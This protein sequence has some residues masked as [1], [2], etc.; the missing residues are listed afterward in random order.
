MTL[1]TNKMFAYG[2]REGNKSWQ[3]VEA[4]FIGGEGVGKTLLIRSLWKLDISE[5][6]P[7]YKKKSDHQRKP[8]IQK[9]LSY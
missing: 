6:A 7:K 2:R 8:S 3:S 9:R 4:T 5:I 1:K